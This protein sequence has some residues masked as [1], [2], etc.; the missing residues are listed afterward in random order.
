[1]NKNI[2]NWLLAGAVFV[3]ATAC[4]KRLDVKPTQSIDENTA[5]STSKD[6]EVT[7]VG[8]YDGLSSINLL[9]GAF[10]YSGEL[11]GDDAEVRFG[12][13]FSTL[14]ELWR[15]TV[16]TT[17]GQTQTTWLAA[18][19]TINRTNN[20]L[21]ALDKVDA[22]SKNRIEGAARFIR[23]VTYFELVRLWGKQ[24]GDGSNS[25]NPGVPLVT[26]PTRGVSDA[27]S[28]PRA[29]VEAVYAQIIEDLTKAESLLGTGSK[30]F[31]TKNAAAAMLARV[32]LQ[33]GNFTGAR[34]AANRVIA[35]AGTAPLAST[36]ANAF[37]DATMDSEVIFKVIVTDQDGGN[38]MNTFFGPTGNP[39]SRGDIRVQTK[40]LNLYGAGDVRG[41]FFTRVSG[42]TFSVKFV[43][44]FGD[45]PVVRMAEMF[46]IRA[47]C[48]QRLN[49]TVGATPLADINRIRSRAGAASLTTVSLANIIA[50]RRLELAFEGTQI[51]DKKRLG[52]DITA[53]IKFNDNKVVLPIP[54]R[55]IDTNKSLTQNA[56]Y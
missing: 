7:L 50:E 10:Q 23:G 41:T 25:T 45:V 2:K 31:A 14:D 30:G 46:L 6:V 39:G 47:E 35:T 20:V 43:D 18:Y 37:S 49:A 4:D 5:L 38:A 22:G 48:N 17:N 51:H 1:M 36:F 42:N 55:E 54:Q 8:A 19:A 29:S 28:R 16:T 12:G 24:W 11:L 34:D 9:G 3:F 13:T 33:Q 32:Y 15:K 21:S 26:T 53:A 56:G 40:H 52:A 27:D 44:R